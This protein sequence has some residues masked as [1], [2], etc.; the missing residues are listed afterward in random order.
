[1]EQQELV[2]EFDE[3]GSEDAHGNDHR[4]D[5]NAEATSK[6]SKQA[7]KKKKKKKRF[8]SFMECL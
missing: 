2:L 4:S 7:S 8:L 3:A 6:V 5:Q 1:M